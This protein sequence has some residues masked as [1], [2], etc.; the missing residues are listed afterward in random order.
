MITIKDELEA[1]YDYL[2]KIISQK[3]A[4]IINGSTNDILRETI[5][6]CK[7]GKGYQYYRKEDKKLRYIQAKDKEVV[8]NSV[9]L[10]YDGKVL[11]AALKEQNK[12]AEILNVYT[13][14][15]VEDVYVS[16]PDGKKILI[17]P[18]SIPDNEYIKLWAEETY[19]PLGFRENSPEFYSSKG[20]RMRSKSEVIIANTLDRLNIVYKYEKPLMIKSMGIVHPDF[21]I[22]NVKERKEIYWEHLGML[23]DQ[24]YRNNAIMK[25]R[26]YEKSGYYV[27]DRLIV[28]EESLSCP[29]DIKYIERKVRFI[30][31]M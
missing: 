16:M 14:R 27:G 21:T 15:S 1:R 26:D 10:E 6:A 11:K 25:I 31:G 4:K 30:L 18:V 5:Y 2:S 23:D 20:E 19:E 28:T 7:H 8:K 17:A 3:K 13:N 22:L 9:Q 12:I 29:I 24:V